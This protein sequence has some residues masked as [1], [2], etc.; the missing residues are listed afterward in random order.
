MSTSRAD[1]LANIRRSFGVRGTE[2]TRQHVVADRISN[3]PIG[4]LPARGQL[5]GAERIAL[6][7][8]MAENAQTDVSQVA[9]TANVPSEIANGG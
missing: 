9:D 2:A 5:D 8:R 6:F 7:I 3:T 4:M 1:I